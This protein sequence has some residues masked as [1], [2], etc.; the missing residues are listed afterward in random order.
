MNAEKL[1]SRLLHLYFRR[2]LF[3]DFPVNLLV[4][5]WGFFLPLFCCLITTQT[6]EWNIGL[7]RRRVAGGHRR[8][9]WVVVLGVLFHLARCLSLQFKYRNEPLIC[10]CKGSGSL[11]LLG[12]RDLG[13][14]CHPE[15]EGLP[16]APGPRLLAS[17]PFI[18][19]SF[20]EYCPTFLL[21][22]KPSRPSLGQPL[23]SPH[24]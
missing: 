14:G 16:T 3:E 6:G 18:G 1:V 12:L 24:T 17:G 5:M 11:R 23:S 8:F 13:E 10:Y 4:K 20:W 22:Q 19:P 21:V 7:G 15:R 9:L 2:C